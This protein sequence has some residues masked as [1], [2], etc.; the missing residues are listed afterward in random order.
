[1]AVGTFWTQEFLAF[2]VAFFVTTALTPAIIQMASRRG[3][4]DLPGFRKVHSSPLPRLGGVAIYFGVWISWAFFLYF[5]PDRV[6]Y[7]NV[8]P[9]WALF[10][11]STL[12]WFLGL[13]DDLRGTNAWQKL[14]VQ[15]AAAAIVT[16][17]GVGIKVLY[18]PFAGDY[19]LHSPVWVWCLTI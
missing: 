6:P 1:M 11:A 12:I 4:L 9:L 15:V 2:V 5:N 7:E 17:A 3:W 10:G 14:T 16:S 13:Y 19:F 8:R 18:N